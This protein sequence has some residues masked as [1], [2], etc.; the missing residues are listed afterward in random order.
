MIEYVPHAYPDLEAVE[1]IAEE[2]GMTKETLVSRSTQKQ[3]AG[4]SSCVFIIA[5]GEMRI[6]AEGNNYACLSGDSIRI[7]AHSDYLVSVGADGCGYYWAEE[8]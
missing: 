4:D 8:D 2:N 7:P 1:I 5:T 6:E 3:R